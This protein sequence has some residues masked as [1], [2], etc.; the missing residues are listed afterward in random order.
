MNTEALIQKL[1]E[2]YGDEQGMKVYVTIMPGIL[3]DFK[4]M[5]SSAAPG[6]E[7][8]EEYRLEDGKGT[9]VVTGMRNASGEIRMDAALN[10]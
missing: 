8:S 7:I 5:L 10:A 3:A 4:K 9:V 1:N 6:E 2:L